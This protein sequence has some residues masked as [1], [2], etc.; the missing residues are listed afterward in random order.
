VA[1]FLHQS[2]LLLEAT[3][4]LGVQ[5]PRPTR[6]LACS[7]ALREHAVQV[8]DSTLPTGMAGL[9]RVFRECDPLIHIAT[10]YPQG[11]QICRR[12][13]SLHL[14]AMQTTKQFSTLLECLRIAYGLVFQCEIDVT[15]EMEPGQLAVLAEDPL[16]GERLRELQD[17]GRICSAPLTSPPTLL[18]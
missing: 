7:L 14:K 12:S 1:Y 10:H 2:V 5:F 13:S 16:S 8:E 18:F 15:L 3:G 4:N 9:G 11:Y 6:I 17:A